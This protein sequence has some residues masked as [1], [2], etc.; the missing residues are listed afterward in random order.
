MHP[1][2]AM[3]GAPPAERLGGIGGLLVSRLGWRGSS[4][5]GL[6]D[7]ATMARTFAYLFGLGATLFVVTLV[8][9]HSA[10]REIGG[11]AAVAIAAYAVAASF[12]IGFDRLPTWCFQLAPLLG[13]VLVSLGI[14][15]AGP[16][17][18]AA[19]AMYYFW[20]ALA[21]CYF[22]RPAVAAT[23]LA[24]A[25][26]AY[27]IVLVL[28]RG[29]VAQ[30]AL[31][32]ALASGTLFGGGAAMMALRGQMRH[33]LSELDS[34]ARTD[35]LTGLAN[36]RQLEDRFAAEIDRATRGGRPLSLL[37]L[38]LD[39]FK[40]FNDR[41]G[42]R[43]GDRALVAFGAALGRATRTSDLVARLGGQEF[44]VLA[45]ETDEPDAFL[46]AERLRAEVRV[47]FA[48]QPE[49]LTVSCGIASF[50][51]HGIAP[52][53]LMYAAD[54]ALYEAKEAGRDR[55]VVFELPSAP[56]AEEKLE[57]GRASPQVEPL[58]SLVEAVDRRKG[59]AAGSRRVAR[60]AERLAR[61]MGLPREEAERVRVAA[62]LRD[63]GE[64]GF[65]ES[66]LSKPE[67]LSDEERREL[68]RHPEIGARIVAAAQLGHV[69]EW[70]LTHHER[71]DG[72]GYPRGLR[73]HQIPLEGRIVAVADAYG[74]MTSRRPYRDSFSPKRAKAE[75]QARAG[76]QFDHD[77]VAAFL[78]LDGEVEPA[79][80]RE[81][82]SADAG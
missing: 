62:L 46:L 21:A 33:L 11:M 6:D 26:L 35:P 59:S 12:L 82:A 56:E 64:V 18:P 61:A 67:P 8:L 60:L 49:K 3:N 71:P 63:V 66:I 53:E 78:S 39:W 54:R 30:P 80:A 15:F 32:W 72:G 36:R 34:V 43:A 79:R 55:A 81:A 57:V 51:A 29:D 25:S 27:A 9:P 7:R 76:S 45:P 5:G 58:V 37:V 77:V 73:G 41:F 65:A 31:K 28:A 23:H 52:G 10:D 1:V 38:D 16:E 13:T 74:A 4:L 48:R 14:Y 20:V 42:H 47:A 68:E 70:I 24:L 17:V 40:E 50:P 75:L 19:Y 44:A 2:A 69:G 22:F